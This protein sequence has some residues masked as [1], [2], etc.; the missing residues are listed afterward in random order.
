MKSSPPD[1]APQKPHSWRGQWI[2]VVCLLI[3][4]LFTWLLHSYVRMVGWPWIVIWQTG[5]LVLGIWT[6]WMLRQFHIPFRRLGYGLDWVAGFTVLTVGLS[7]TLAEF[8]QVAAWNVVLAICYGMLL[9]ILRNWITP[10]GFTVQRAWLAIVLVGGVT[11]LISLALWRPTLGMWQS[12]NFVEAIRNPLPLGHHNFVGG[13]FNLMLPLMVTFALT[14][15]GWKRWLSG[16][17]SFLAA[18]ALY[19]SGSRGAMLGVLVWLL[20]S[21]GIAIWR[22]RDK[23]RQWLIASGFLA[24]LGMAFLLLSN[25]RVRRVISLQTLFNHSP[26]TDVLI[27]DGP[28]LDRLFMLKAAGHI[29]QKHP[30]LGVGPGNMSRVYNL[31]RPI[32]AGTGLDHVQQLHNTPAQIGGELGL[33]GLIAYIMLLGCLGYL[34]FRL[35]R[36]LTNPQDRLLMVGVGGSLLSYGISS[37]TDYQL[38]NIGIAS[39]LTWNVALLIG[40]ADSCLLHQSISFKIPRRSRRFLSLAALVFACLAVRIWL[41][42]DVAMYLSQSARQ[43]ATAGNP[44]EADQQW[45]KAARLTPWDPTYS[46]LAAKNVLWVKDRVSGDD[47]QV[48]SEQAIEYFKQAIAAAPNDTWFNQNLA[49]LL[50]EQDPPNFNTAETYASRTAQLQARNRNYTFYLLA[51]IYLTQS[52]EEEAIAALT[53]QGLIEPKFLTFSLW[54]KQPFVSFKTTVLDKTLSLFE[55]LLTSTPPNAP[56]YESLNESAALLRWWH[57]YPLTN[58]DRERLRPIVKALLQAEPEPTA[59][60]DLLNTEITADN[61][62]QNLRLLR[63]WLD[64]ENYLDVY[65]GEYASTTEEQTL[66]EEFIQSS[67]SIRS[68]LM[69]S[70]TDHRSGELRAGLVFA[71]R[72]IDINLPQPVLRPFGLSANP[73]ADQLMVFPDYP[74]EFPQLDYLLETLKADTLNLPHPTRN[75]FQLI[76]LMEGGR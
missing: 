26:T 15:R 69:S 2:G 17:A 22:S 64:P 63:A 71:Y 60:L 1:V 46:A 44:A 40:L 58:I 41:P 54:T 68:G 47:Q 51:L 30:L 20:V 48:L 3:L 53:I 18:G 12:N 45:D 42:G 7:A 62:A 43:E 75:D 34:W 21:F 14:Q 50:L 52:R 35:D 61:S 70:Q 23:Q 38:E 73:L 28:I 9:Y 13:Y 4:A 72:N 11:S 16:G 6:I 5:F 33:L 67:A 55:T 25:P 66:I 36:Q 39:T 74:R 31:Y 57:R 37:L 24:L 56:G 8:P 76:P 32:E 19:S 49:V 59:A 29:L 65:L 10:D 27:R